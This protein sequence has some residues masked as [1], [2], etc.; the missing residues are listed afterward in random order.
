MSGRER[1]PKLKEDSKSIKLKDEINGILEELLE[2]NVSDITE[3]NNL[4]YSA[5]ILITEE[6]NQPSKRGKNRRNEKFWK[7][8]MERQISSWRKQISII[9]ETGTGYGNSTLNRKR[10]RF[11]KNIKWQMPEKRHS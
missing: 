11:F 2:K 1:L 7:I 5:A 10:G 3:I 6:A 8:R 4:I 9:P